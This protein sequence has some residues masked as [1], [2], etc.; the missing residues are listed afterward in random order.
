MVP[1]VSTLRVRLC[2]VLVL[3]SPPLPTL[4]HHTLP[5]YTL[6]YYPVNQ[7]LTVLAIV[8]VRHQCAGLWLSSEH[9]QLPRFIFFR[10]DGV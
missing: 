5:Y 6:P 2:I 9:I 3:I 4:P 7:G 8:S 10:I 1:C